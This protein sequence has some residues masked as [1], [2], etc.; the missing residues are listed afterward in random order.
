[1]LVKLLWSDLCY[2]C[3]ANEKNKFALQRLSH[4][5]NVTPLATVGH[6]AIRSPGRFIN[7]GMTRLDEV[8]RGYM[9]GKMASQLP[10]SW[11][12]GH[13][14]RLYRHPSLQSSANILESRGPLIHRGCTQTKLSH[15]ECF[16]DTKW[17]WL[18][19]SFWEVKPRKMP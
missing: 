12:H 6:V 15:T 2:H 18:R 17:F 3:F 9:R 4:S 8:Q 5:A 11:L 16:Q 14:L 19:Q 1:M 7:E 13:S 10:A